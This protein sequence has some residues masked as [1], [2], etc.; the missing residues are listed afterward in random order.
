LFIVIQRHNVAIGKPGSCHPLVCEKSSIE[1][2]HCILYT[3]SKDG[4][5]PDQ[6][7]QRLAAAPHNFLT[8]LFVYCD[9]T[10]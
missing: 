3:G 6:G 2:V 5:H 7:K 1:N 9:A 4:G 10:A 8:F